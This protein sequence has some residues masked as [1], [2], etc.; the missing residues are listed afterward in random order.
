[1][2]RGCRSLECTQCQGLAGA[3]TRDTMTANGAEG[4]TPPCSTTVSGIFLYE[5]EYFTFTNT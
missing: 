2:K 1:M 3:V 5:T 4:D